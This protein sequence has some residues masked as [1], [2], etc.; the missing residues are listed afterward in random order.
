MFSREPAGDGVLEKGPRQGPPWSGQEFLALAAW[1]GPP[2]LPS[3]IAKLLLRRDG[4]RAATLQFGEGG[5]EGGVAAT[6]RVYL[7]VSSLS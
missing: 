1:R 7:E 4:V 5:G 6:F 2:P 3:Q